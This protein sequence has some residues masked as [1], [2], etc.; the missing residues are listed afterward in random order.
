MCASPVSSL[1]RRLINIERL[2]SRDMSY[3]ILHNPLLRLWLNCGGSL[4]HSPSISP[5]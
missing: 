3:L 5:G 2:E 1:A 4:D